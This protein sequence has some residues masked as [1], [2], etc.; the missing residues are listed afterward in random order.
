[1][2]FI[3]DPRNPINVVRATNRKEKGGSPEDAR[4]KGFPMQTVLEMPESIKKNRPIQ[5]VNSPERRASIWLE[6][7]LR[8]ARSGVVSLEIEL[9]PALAT[10]LLNRNP[11]NRNVSE[12][13]VE[14]Y[15]RDIANGSWAFNGQTIIVAD[16]GFL[17]DG[18][19][20]CLGVEAAKKSIRT[21]I[22]I[23]VGRDTRYTLDQGRNRMAS[24][25][26]SMQGYKNANQLGAA[27][28][29]LWQYKN[30]GK[31]SSSP[32]FRPTK[33]E[34]LSVVEEYPILDRAIHA[35]NVKGADLI[36]GKAILAFTFHLISSAAGHEAAESFMAKLLNGD[37]LG[38]GHPILYARNRLMAERGHLKAN[39]RADI[40][41]KAWNY[42]RRGVSGKTHFKASED[43]LPPVER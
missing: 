36:G 20:R 17:N 42:S 41:L 4:Q 16:D 13:F 10:V 35:A 14:R 15:S 39:E 3:D 38:A 30:F 29:Y 43:T 23:G 33:G 24:D 5:S 2:R 34:I 31:L 28:S 32:K 26:L 12:G 27:G 40:I 22:V 1:M 9:T 6:E 37:D 19:H 7:Q 8:Q 21:I 18:Q 11:D 25:Y